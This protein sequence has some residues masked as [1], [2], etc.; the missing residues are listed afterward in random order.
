MHK[1]TSAIKTV[2]RLPNIKILCHTAIV[3]DWLQVMLDPLSLNFIYY[4]YGKTKLG[5]QNSCMKTIQRLKCI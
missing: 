2:V 1:E 4:F 3:T 5:C